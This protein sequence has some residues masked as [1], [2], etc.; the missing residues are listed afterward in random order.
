MRIEGVIATTGMASQ[1]L[2]E[3]TAQKTEKAAD[4]QLR[5]PA[6]PAQQQ[7][8]E[9]AKAA[10]SRLLPEAV[11]QLEQIVHAFDRNLK[12]QIHEDTRSVMVQV[13]NAETNEVI[14]EFPSEQILDMVSMFQKQLSGLFVDKLR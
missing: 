4:A 8:A 12:F 5:Q 11:K 3:S 13:L 7:A 10:G 6:T 2:A 1:Q 14:R 9:E